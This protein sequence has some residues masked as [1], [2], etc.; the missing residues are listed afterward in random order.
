MSSTWIP[1]MQVSIGMIL[2]HLSQPVEE[3]V[4]TLPSLWK[5]FDTN[6]ADRNASKGAFDKGK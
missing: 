4:N 5:Y 2:Y 1:I 6:Q 3:C